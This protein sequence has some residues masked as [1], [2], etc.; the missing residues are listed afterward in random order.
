MANELFIPSFPNADSTG[1]V[2]DAVLATSIA[3]YSKT[4]TDNIYQSNVLLAKLNEN[5]L[6]INGGV[7]KVYPLIKS[8]QDAG[9]FY[10]GSQ[11]LNTTQPDAET[12]VEY[13]WQNV[14]EPIQLNR[15][16]ERSNSG[17]LHK[18]VDLVGEKI[19]RS[20][21]SIANRVEEAFSTPVAEANN[22]VDLE[23]LANTGTLGTIAGGSETFWQS[24][25]T[26]SGSFAA[27]GLSDMSTAYY[28]VSSSAHIDNP[29]FLITNKTIFQSY[30]QTRSP[31][32][33]IENGN[34][35]ANARFKNLT[36][37]GVEL[38][39][40]NSIGTGLLFGL[41]MSYIDYIVDSMTDFVMTPFLMPVN[42]TAK[43][44]YI[45]LRTMGPVTNNRR[46]HFKL[47]GV[48]A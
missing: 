5:K 34:L 43:V 47:T 20:E 31:L 23:T 25:V 7:S 4:I 33:R 15:D 26:A 11:E 28:D 40:G 35:T 30:E 27:Q 32:E 24:T 6:T 12:Q 21:L 13:R 38:F 1:E 37:K 46:R 41:N 29:D 39:Y 48:T 42:Q 10:L 2:S 45:L 18:I 14:Y 16:E 3:D 22:I 36:F 19:Q 8:D 9:G 17:D 44:A